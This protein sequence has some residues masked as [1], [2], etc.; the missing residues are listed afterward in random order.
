MGTFMRLPWMLPLSHSRKVV[1]LLRR[2]NDGEVFTLD[3]KCLLNSHF[4]RVKTLCKQFWPHDWF[5]VNQGE[6]NNLVSLISFS[7]ITFGSDILTEREKQ[8]I[9]LVIQGLDN[10]AIAANL[11]ISIATVKVHRKSIYNKF[12][13][14]S[15]GELFQVFL[16]H[17]V[18]HS[19][20]PGSV[21]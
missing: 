8:V 13:V 5:T 16:N 19:N 6:S 15:L 11:R 7:L 17:L 1:I 10:K 14:S 9:N 20:K 4:H 21:M 2:D 18:E 12:E 3:D